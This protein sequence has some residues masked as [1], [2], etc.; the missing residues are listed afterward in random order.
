MKHLNEFYFLS[1]G[2]KGGANNFLNQHMNYL[3]EN[4]KK[5][6]LIDKDPKKTYEKLHNKI[7]SHKLNINK[8]K[9]NIKNKLNQIIKYNNYKTK[10]IVITN[11]AILIKYFWFLKKFRSENNK[12]ILTIHSGIFNI[13]LKSFIAGLIFSIIYGEIDYLFFGSISAKLWW[14]NTYPWMKIKKN[15]V[16]YNGVKIKKNSIKKIGKQIRISFA[17]RLEKENNPNFFLEIAEVYLKKDKNAIFNVF[18][19]GSLLNVLKKQYS[20]NKIIFHG[21]VP[22]EKIY[23][24]SDLI[25]ITAPINN[26]P[27]VALES[28]SYGIPVLSCSKGD[29]SKIIKNN[30]D[31]YLLKTNSRSKMIDYIKKIRD[32]YFE[33][34][35]NSIKRSKKYELNLSCKKFWNSVYV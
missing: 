18:G 33:F 21:W 22:K 26:Y 31:G 10:Y 25:I 9:K 1:D 17:G 27:Y 3:A 2:Y 11:Y 24:K 15:L 32:N 12:I 35:K 6:I 29:I 28:K 4:N 34:S 20:N 14:K 7:I 13:N 30:I 8:N 5:V 23:L 16:H 19:N